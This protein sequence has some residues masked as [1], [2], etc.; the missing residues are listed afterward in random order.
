[1]LEFKEITA[2]YEEGKSV[3]EDVSFIV[4]KPSVVGIIGPNGAGKSTFIKAALKL[5][6]GSGSF[7]RNNENLQVFQNKIA[8]VEQKSAIDYTFPI[9]VSEVVSLG[10]F[11]K[12]RPWESLRPKWSQVEDALKIVKMTEFADR[13]IGELSGGQFQRVLLARTIVQDADL[14]FL[15]EPFVGIDTTSEKIIMDLL[16]VFRT[17]G[18][19][20]FIVH[21]DLSKVK[22]YFDELLI[23][24]HRQIA[25]GATEEVFTEDN[26]RH[27]YGEGIVIGGGR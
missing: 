9:T 2:A 22:E 25:F 16:Q 18:K 3:V 17:T 6:P 8:Y 23:L 19:T 4:E 5:I 12:V 1:M 24:N 20:I 26:L 10:L 27:A 15:D 7:T 13:Q 21:H 11:P 14:I